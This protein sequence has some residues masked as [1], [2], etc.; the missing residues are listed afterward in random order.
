[1][2]K[3]SYKA[4][5]FN[6]DME[7]WKQEV[8][9]QILFNEDGTVKDGPCTK[10]VELFNLTINNVISWEWMKF[11]FTKKELRGLTDF[12]NQFIEET[13]ESTT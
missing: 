8:P 13:N 6:F 2:T 4:D 1:V 5:I 9:N 7:C 12:L 3:D 10:K 11:K